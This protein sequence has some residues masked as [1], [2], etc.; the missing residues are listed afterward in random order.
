MSENMQTAQGKP[1][2]TCENLPATLTADEA[3]FIRLYRAGK[4]ARESGNDETSNRVGWAFID[5]L[6]R[7]VEKPSDQTADETPAAPE[8]KPDDNTFF[9]IAVGVVMTLVQE[10]DFGR[11]L[12]EWDDCSRFPI[13]PIIRAVEHSI[14]QNFTLD[15]LDDQNIIFLLNRLYE[16]QCY[17]YRIEKKLIKS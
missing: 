15:K 1:E 4:A 17:F 8:P 14:W 12:A 10:F 2:T 16:E 3:E 13:V 6:S 11:D 7:T 5:L 9:N